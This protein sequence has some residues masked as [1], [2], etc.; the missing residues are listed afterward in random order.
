MGRVAGSV[1]LHSPRC[2]FPG[3]RE[4][5]VI[6]PASSNDGSMSE[7]AWLAVMLGVAFITGLVL[8]WRTTPGRY[9]LAAPL[10]FVPC[11][12]MVV[13]LLPF[14]LFGFL[15]LCFV[16]VFAWFFWPFLYILMVVPAALGFYAGQ[17][18]RARA[19]AH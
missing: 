16:F 15:G 13:L 2:L 17:R 14:V 3:N 10:V 9:G 11:A 6:A 5:L 12:S 8:G 1:G 7:T 18:C 19:G 4:K